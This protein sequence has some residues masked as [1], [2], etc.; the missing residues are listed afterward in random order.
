LITKD[1]NPCNPSRKGRKTAIPHDANLY[2]KRH[3]I[4][5]MFA[6]LKDWRGIAKRYDRCADLFLSACALAATI[7]HFLAWMAKVLS[8]HNACFGCGRYSGGDSSSS[9]QADSGIPTPGLT[10]ETWFAPFPGK[11]RKSC[12]FPRG[13]WPCQQSE[14]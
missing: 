12:R 9:R 1:I 10:G 4:E 6:R 7:R 14:I 11:F 13:N 3:K 8:L 2:R 5:N